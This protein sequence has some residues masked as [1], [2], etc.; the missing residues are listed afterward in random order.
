M[1]SKSPQRY[2]PP[3]CRQLC[4]LL[5][6]TFTEKKIYKNMAAASVKARS[7]QRSEEIKI[8][9]A[10]P[11]SWPHELWVS[12]K[13]DTEVRGWS[14]GRDTS[15]GKQVSEFTPRLKIDI[16]VQ[17]AVYQ[18]DIIEHWLASCSPGK[19]S[20]LTRGD[21]ASGLHINTSSRHHCTPVRI[22]FYPSFYLDFHV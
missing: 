6:F 17:A 18:V 13:Q 20:W 22:L 7:V 14:V 10:R 2:K 8:N 15:S 19:P 3:V 12:E 9:T 11:P 16:R 4:I 1:N 21:L 5:S